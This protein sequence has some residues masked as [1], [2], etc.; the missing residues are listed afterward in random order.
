MQYTQ[1]DV[2]L[3]IKDSSDQSIINL[4]AIDICK[5][6][7]NVVLLPDGRVPESVGVY[8]TQ[9]KNLANQK[10]KTVQVKT[11]TLSSGK[12]VYVTFDIEVIA[13]VETVKIHMTV[14]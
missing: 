8:I 4:L 6:F 1:D 11:V 13:T 7:E 2:L 14:V 10:L 3:K 5:E 12:E 9:L